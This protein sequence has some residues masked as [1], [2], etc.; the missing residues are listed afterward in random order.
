MHS[1]LSI[2]WDVGGVKHGVKA[3]HGAFNL[4]NFDRNT[5]V[6]QKPGMLLTPL[7]TFI[8]PS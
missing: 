5:V 7:L 6:P 4:M 8:S 2:A 1:A 3:V